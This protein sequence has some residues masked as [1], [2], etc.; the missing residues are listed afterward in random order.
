MP[1][2]MIFKAGKYAQGDWPKERVQKLV[3]AYDPEKNMEAPVVIGHR[4][5]GTDDD[6]QDAHGWVI[7]LR[8]DGAGKVFARVGEFSGDVKKKIAEGKLRYVSAEIY[9]FDK[10][11]AA[12]APYLKAVALLGRDTPAVAGTKVSLFGLMAGGGLTVIDEKENLTAFTRKAGA[13]EIKSFAGD[14]GR[15]DTEMNELEQSKEQVTTLQAELAAE[16]EKLAAFQRETAELRNAGKKGDAEAYFSKLRDEGKL[17]PA[18]FD[19]AVALDV[20]LGDEERKAF[21]AMFD[22]MVSQVDLSGEHTASKGRAPA[23]SAGNSDVTA[24][25]RAYQKERNFATFAEAAEAL[26]A[27][28]PELFE[29]GGGASRGG[30]A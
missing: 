6:Y 9:E 27:S 13:E 24:K 29:E 14:G 18:Q 20:N 19:K 25:I 1:E 30:V 28:K 4:F 2:I 22:G 23:A 8:M 3:D 7:G 11:D 10:V 5:Y 16:K 17:A 12:R 26:Y 21:R 15:E